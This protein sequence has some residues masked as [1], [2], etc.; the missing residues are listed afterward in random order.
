MLD[1]FGPLECLNQ[2]VRLTGFEDRKDLSLVILAKTERPVS[3][4]PIKGDHDPFNVHVAQSIVPTHTFS[5]AQNNIDVLLVPGG[6]GTG[7]QMDSSFKPDVSA[8]VA[9]IAKVF[10]RLK[11]LISESFRANLSATWLMLP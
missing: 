1:V 8:E 5:N 3:S 4:G 7:P 2:I 9:F 11:Y 10:P 6:C